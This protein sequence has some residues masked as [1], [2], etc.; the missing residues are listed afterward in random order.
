M[1]LIDRLTDREISVGLAAIGV[2]FV[3]GTLF[4]L[5][6]IPDKGLST[7]GEYGRTGYYAAYLPISESMIL[8]PLGVLAICGYLAYRSYTTEDY[9]ADHA[10]RGEPEEEPAAD[11]GETTDWPTPSFKL[12]GEGYSCAR[13]DDYVKPNDGDGEAGLLTAGD[14][15]KLCLDCARHIRDKLRD[16]DNELD[17]TERERIACDLVEEG[18]TRKQAGLMVDRT[19]SWVSRAVARD[20]EAEQ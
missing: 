19:A 14:T 11:G 15:T 1:T 7:P 12:P 18:Y 3:V 2:G 9:F 13:C 6:S 20:Q 4:T 10:L 17:Q 5:L 16:E 8:V